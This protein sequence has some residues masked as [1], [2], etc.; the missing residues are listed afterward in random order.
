MLA[1]SRDLGVQC[2]TA[3]ALAHKLREAMIERNGAAP[4]RLDTIMD[5]PASREA[6]GFLVDMR[7]RP[8]LSVRICPFLECPK[9][10][11]TC[12]KG[13]APSQQEIRKNHTVFC[14]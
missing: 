5:D 1:F 10:E 6:F 7:V 9:A 3:F 12:R 13:D 8:M 14:V 2:K 4:S 11:P